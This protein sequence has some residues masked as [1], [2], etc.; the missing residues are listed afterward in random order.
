[1]AK[2]TWIQLDFFF[3]LHIALSVTKEKWILFFL[4]PKKNNSR[5][6]PLLYQLMKTE[7]KKQW[8][9]SEG[10]SEEFLVHM[11]SN[12]QAGGNKQNNLKRIQ[13]LHIIN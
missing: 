1:M 12:H 9:C 13:F 10:K 5:I 11:I 8:T 6:K 7:N 3:L 2:S 4:S